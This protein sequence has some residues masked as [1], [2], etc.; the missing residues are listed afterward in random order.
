MRRDSHQVT[1]TAAAAR[2]AATITAASI[3]G[4]RSESSRTTSATRPTRRTA[5]TTTDSTQR[6]IAVRRRIAIPSVTSSRTDECTRARPTGSC[7]RI[8]RS[9]TIR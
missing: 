1:A 6:H 7:H 3:P 2:T 4:L 8:L 9:T 5:A